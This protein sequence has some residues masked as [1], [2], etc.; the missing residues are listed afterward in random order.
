[1]HFY[2]RTGLRAQEPIIAIWM[3]KKVQ[4]HEY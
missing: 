2:P 1:M 4:T 3:S